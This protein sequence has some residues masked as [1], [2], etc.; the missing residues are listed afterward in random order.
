MASAADKRRGAEWGMEL[1]SDLSIEGKLDTMKGPWAFDID[2]ARAA[3]KEKADVAVF[4]EAAKKSWLR[5]Q[6]EWLTKDKWF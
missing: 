1:W 3:K 6:K 2:A 4:T 5:A